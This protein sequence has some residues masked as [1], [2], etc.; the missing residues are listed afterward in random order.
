MKKSTLKTALKYTLLFT[1]GLPIALLL[2]ICILITNEKI[3]K[4]VR[5]IIYITYILACL[6]A[7]TLLFG[8]YLS[9]T[10]LSVF[11]SI[12]TSLFLWFIPII[13]EN[14]KLLKSTGGG[15]ISNNAPIVFPPIAGF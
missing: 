11:L 9:F 12:M 10:H 4:K 1:I 2:Y 7:T 15:A 14:P 8:F 3:P 13:L 5:S 6:A